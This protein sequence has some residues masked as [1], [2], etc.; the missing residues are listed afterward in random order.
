[1]VHRQ[2]IDVSRDT[3][4]ASM[5]ELGA[6]CTVL[7]ATGRTARSAAAR[8]RT[9]ARLTSRTFFLREATEFPPGFAIAAG[10]LGYAYRLGN[11]HGSCI[12]I[13]GA[14]DLVAGSWPELLVR[15][16]SFAEWLVSDL[17]GRQV[18]AGKAGPSFMQWAVPGAHANLIGDAELAYD[19]LSS[20]GLAIG[21]SGALHAVSSIV[22]GTTPGPPRD[23]MPAVRAHAQRIAGMI[24]SG[25]FASHPQWSGY[26]TF[27]ID[28]AATHTQPHALV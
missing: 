11:A 27:L 10:P 4:R 17:E 20:Q 23:T 7:D 13:V 12:G 24:K 9:N 28:T 15:V 21:L 18:L 22:L 2:G 6:D 5:A 14:G 16:G 8:H 3:D 25:P 1:M 19:A 26:R